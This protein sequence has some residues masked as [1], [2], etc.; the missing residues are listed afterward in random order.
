MNTSNTLTLEEAKQQII[1]LINNSGIVPQ[2]FIREL[3]SVYG[4]KIVEDPYTQLNQDYK[5]YCDGFVE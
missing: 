1:E 2:D 4:I 5:T 3:A